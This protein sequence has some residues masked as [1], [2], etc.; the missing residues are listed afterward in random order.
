MNGV[1]IAAAL[2]TAQAATPRG[3]DFGIHSLVEVP[4]PYPGMRTFDLVIDLST[5]SAFF[6]AATM[7][8]SVVNGTFFDHA[9]VHAGDFAPNPALF[10]SDPLL[11]YDTFLTSPDVFPTTSSYDPAELGF[12][13]AN[14][15]GISADGRRLGNVYGGQDAQAGIEWSA[16]PITASTGTIA[17]ITVMGDA[18]LILRVYGDSLTDAG[19]FLLPFDLTVPEP[20]LNGIGVAV[21]MLCVL[22]RRAH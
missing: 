13:T 5:P 21:L 3:D 11:E 12:L 2:L 10:A 18:D 14:D 17:R 9:S 20:K 6:V 16:F 1:L 4:N 8:A 7:H 15:L 22:G 19:D